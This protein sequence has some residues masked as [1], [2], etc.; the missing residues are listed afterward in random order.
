MRSMTREL[1]VAACPT[2]G[3]ESESVHER[4][5]D[6]EVRSFFVCTYCGLAWSLLAI[7]GSPTQCSQTKCD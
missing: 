5:T 1:S 4:R 6:D 2:C 3:T 7:P